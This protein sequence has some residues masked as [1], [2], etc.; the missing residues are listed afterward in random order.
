MKKFLATLMALCC[1]AL[2]YAQTVDSLAIDGQIFVKIRNS[3]SQSFPDFNGNEAILT[4]DL[5]RLHAIYHLTKISKPFKA[6]KSEK[7]QKTYLF[8]FEN[9][10]AVQALITELKA[11]SYVEYAEQVPIAHLSYVPNDPNSNI[12]GFDNRNWHFKKINAE[13]GWDFAPTY[14]VIV[15]V[16]DNEIDTNH[17]DLAANIWQNNDPVNGVDDDSNGYIDDLNGWDMADN[18]NSTIA[19]AAFSHGSHVS[20]LVGAVTNNSIGIASIGGMNPNIRIMPLKTTYNS[21]IGQPTSL[22]G[23]AIINA[24]YYAADNNANIISMS[25]GMGYSMT[26]ENAIGYAV[27]TKSCLVVAAAGNSNTTSTTSAFPAAFNDSGTYP[28]LYNKVIAVGA[29]DEL[30]HKASFSNYGSWVDVMAPGNN[31]YSSDN[32]QITN[33]SGGNYSYKSGTSMATPQVS[34]LCALLYGLDNTLSASAI[35]NIVK[36]TARDIY[37]VNPSYTG[38]LGTG[39]IDVCAAALYA[40][41]TYSINFSADMVNACP[42]STIALSAFA[43]PGITVTNWQ[44]NFSSAVTYVSGNQNTQNISITVGSPTVLSATLTATTTV[45]T[46]TLVKPNYI[47]INSPTATMQAAA[48]GSLCNG[49]PQEFLLDFDGGA[50][51]FTYTITNG[52]TTSTYTSVTSTDVYYFVADPNYVSYTMTAMSDAAGCI[53]NN[54]AGQ[55]VTIIDCCQNLVVNGDFEQ[56]NVGITSGNYYSCNAG[57]TAPGWYTVTDYPTTSSNICSEFPGW[58]YAANNNQSH[59]HKHISMAYDGP[60]DTGP[61]IAFNAGIGTPTSNS[62]YVHTI[63]SQTITGINAGENYNIDFFVWSYENYY[64][65][66]KL[67]FDVLDNSSG[68]LL[69]SGTIDQPSFVGWKQYSYLWNNASYTGNVTLK[70]SQIKAFDYVFFDIAV[71]DISMRRNNASNGAAYAGQDYTICAGN[72]FSLSGSGGPSYTWSPSASLSASNIA[73]PVASPTVTTIYTL[74]VNNAGCGTS[75]DQVTVTVNPVPTLTVL[76]TSTV[77]CAAQTASLYVYGA[78]S[79]SWTPS[80]GLSSTTAYSV[81]ASPSVTTTYSVTGINSYGCQSTSVITVSVVPA[82]TVAVTPSSTTICNGTG[83]TLYASGAS[84]YVWVPGY[85]GGSSLY[86][87]P[88]ST[89][90]YT[91]TGS[92]GVCSSSVTAT[93]NVGATP[94]LTVT[95]TNTAVCFKQSLTLTAAGAS[96]YSWTPSIDLNASTGAVVSCTPGATTI[97]TVTGTSAAGCTATATLT[98]TVNPLPSLTVTPSFTAICSGQS[99]PLNASGASTYSWSPPDGLSATSGASVSASPTVTTI[100]TV[101]GTS[102][103][104]CTSQAV[105]TVSV[106]TMPTV[107]VS[108]SIVKICAGQSATL[109]ACCAT[110]YSWAPGSSLSTTTGSVVVATPSVTT[111]YTVTASNGACTVQAVRAV[112]VAPLPSLTVTPTSTTICSGQSTTLTV[113]GAATYSWSPG[114]GLSST[115]NSVV[116]ASPSV[117]TVYT[118]TGTTGGCSSQISTTVTVLP[119]PTLTVVASPTA[120]CSGQT[121]TLTASGASTYSWGPGTSLYSTTGSSV[122]AGPT[123]TTVYTVTGTGA[124]GCSSTANVTVTVFALPSLTIT[125]SATA[126]CSG[127]SA[128]LTAA[129]AFTYSWSPGT[130]L[131]ATT[132]SSVISTPSATI[133]YTVTGTSS[134]GCSSQLTCTVTVNPLPT[135]TVSPTT[136]TVCSGQS[137]TLTAGGASTYS[138]APGTGLN[139]TT[140]SSVIATPGSTTIYTVTGT[141]AAGCTGKATATLTVKPTPTVGVNPSVLNYCIGNPVTLTASGATTYAWLPTTYL[142]PTTGSVVVASPTTSTIYTVTGTTNGCSGTATV[143]VI[144]STNTC[145]S[146]T[147]QVTSPTSYAGSTNLGFSSPASISIMADITFTAGVSTI[148]CND[149]RIAPGVQITVKN[150]ATLRISASWLH[151]CATCSGGMWDGIYAENGATLTISGNSFIE[152]ASAAV[153][154][155]FYSSGT[156]V[157]DIEITATV[158]NKNT[159]AIKLDLNNPNNVQALGTPN[160]V[161]NSVF[162]CRNLSSLSTPIPSSTNFNAVKAA[163]YTNSGTYATTTTNSGVRSIHGMALTGAGTNTYPYKIGEAASTTTAGVGTINIFDYLDYGVLAQNSVF[164]IKNNLFQNLKGN[165]LSTPIGVGIYEATTSS[166]Y[167]VVIGGTGANEGNTFKTC[168]RAVDLTG[169]DKVYIYNN[170]VNNAA[171]DAYTNFATSGSWS[172]QYGVFLK[173]TGSSASVL[174]IDGNSISNCAYGVHINRSTNYNGTSTSVN[175][176]T[177]TAGGTS[178]LYCNTGVF[179]EDVTGCSTCMSDNTMDITSNTITYAENQAIHCTNILSGLYIHCNNELSIRYRN[180]TN[181]SI[182]GTTYDV[183]RLDNCKNTNTDHNV[184]IKTSGGNTAVNNSNLTGIYINNSGA[185]GNNNVVTYNEVNYLGSCIV[186]EGSNATAATFKY[187]KMTSGRHGMYMYTGAHFTNQSM[188]A[189]RWGNTTLTNHT[190]VD[191]G[192]SYD[193]N[194]STSDSKLT[195]KNMG[196]SGGFAAV[197]TINGG[198]PAY[199]VGT[200]SS[201]GII[202]ST[203]SEASCLNCDCA[204][205]GPAGKASITS[206][207]TDEAPVIMTANADAIKHLLDNARHDDLYTNEHQWANEKLAYELLNADR[208]LYESDKTLQTFYRQLQSGNIGLLTLAETAIQSGRYAEAMDHVQAVNPVN[209][210][211]QN[212]KTVYTILLNTLQN[213]EADLSGYKAALWDIAN[214]CEHAGGAGVSKARA[215]YNKLSNQAI[216]FESSCENRPY[217]QNQETNTVKGGISV[218]LYPNPG[219]GEMTL[220]YSG[221]NGQD[222]LFIIY[223]I[224]GNQLYTAAMPADGNRIAIHVKELMNGVYMYKVESGTVSVKTGKLII[225]K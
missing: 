118:A 4:K 111:N 16:I 33:P 174:T 128:T 101:T 91:V 132:G 44:W 43:G 215:L 48:S 97:Y 213:R 180:V 148:V 212:L 117:T 186:W 60:C 82:P 121:S 167:S 63:W 69:S 127:Q 150:G 21:W 68:T 143:S 100:Y 192:V 175:N 30:D 3:S 209:V 149:V 36:T 83:T 8:E 24:I 67:Q 103:A 95:P 182:S 177:I 176:N 196:V 126:I 96:T 73:Q 12:A 119:L 133:I 51:P 39:I 162:T 64:S 28:T 32:T 145:T 140:G 42:G 201:F 188:C 72:T 139:T 106:N 40:S 120:I 46:A 193:Y 107:T 87:N 25:L 102:A 37:P 155:Q 38:Q 163:L 92:N 116:T 173:P 130:G 152:D 123:S 217:I 93:V 22:S 159:T 191:N 45:G 47:N 197:P 170:V 56:G 62:G 184:Y 161:D 59:L 202:T 125:P 113:S 14:S 23:T 153:S 86:V 137:T 181:N 108:P 146:S 75:T 9:K 76:S 179:L 2:V 34:S 207:D 166:T 80:A 168:L 11:L 105:V 221:L 18:D 104:G 15:A 178:S 220:D 224:H 169:T 222:A 219:Q 185:A 35:E 54:P 154:T 203:L 71:D 58:V 41:N 85:Y 214:Q 124:N 29:T 49:S 78:S 20:G 141:S 52:Y 81:A 208:S 194:L 109:T 172:G 27:N 144:T 57:N 138:W 134:R 79:Y 199:S 94:V 190:Y 198:A 147:A 189:N 205:G 225:V 112:S 210:P 204:G 187:N 98:V 200:T 151:S 206:P 218:N 19:P 61:G 114:S 50:P 31:I 1:Y 216:L 135:V 10:K 136:A 53:T 157:P 211:E 55:S 17:P 65:G 110:S 70:L 6:L 160:I 131:N 5:Q 129:G 66:M 158:F 183:I 77:I 26:L 89:T 142:S 165:C 13:C 115:T 164:D 74:T 223:D 88:G 99:T 122:V 84:S 171:T 7:V 195:V 90:I 156:L